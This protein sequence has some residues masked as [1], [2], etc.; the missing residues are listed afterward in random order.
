MLDRNGADV[1]EDTGAA[2]IGLIVV[3]ILA[4]I[5]LVLF[6]AGLISVLASK[7]YTGGGKFLW[8]VVIFALPLL[9]PLGWF[10]AGRT[11]QIR[12]TAP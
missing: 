10:I 7:R 1:I 12:T 9:G 2:W 11:A 4:A 5:Q 3:W 6:I 8:V